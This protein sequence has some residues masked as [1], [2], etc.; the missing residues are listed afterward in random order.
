MLMIDG[1]YGEGGGQLVRNAVALSAITGEPITINR[2]RSTRDKKGLGPQHIAAIR[3]VAGACDASCTGTTPGSDS[4]TFSP[5]VLRACDVSV[6]VGTAGS[7]PLVIQAWLSVALIVGGRLTVAGGT[8]VPK[9][10]TIDYLKHVLAGVLRNSGADISVDV[11]KRGYFPEGGG[12]VT[13]EVKRKKLL[14]I[15]PSEFRE[16]STSVV[17]AS[18]NLPDH[19][20]DR[21]ASSAARCLQEATGLQATI[22]IDRQ[23][24]MSTGSSCTIWRGSKGS[25]SLGRQ[26]VPAEKIGMI[27]A[28]AALEAFG[29]PGEV[30]EFLSDQLLVPLAISGGS[31]TACSLTSHAETT[32]WLLDQFGYDVK[33]ESGHVVEFS[34]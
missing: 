12:E 19:V 25:S 6:V 11:L 27:A 31:Y 3:S 22:I 30:D 8:E 32:I 23:S 7:I 1:S 14:A 10:P 18:S 29:C 34:A 21:Q 16:G 20:A 4:I 28:C 2:I 33:C 24:G 17:S 13:I 15:H 9:S 5:N 26:G